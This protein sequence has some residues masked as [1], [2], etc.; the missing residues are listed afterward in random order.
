VLRLQVL[1]S[2][3]LGG[4]RKEGGAEEVEGAGRSNE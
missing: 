1:H 4:G 3:G 2:G